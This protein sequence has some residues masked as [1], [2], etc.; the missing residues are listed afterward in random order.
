MIIDIVNS[1]RNSCKY[2]SVKKYSY[3]L[4][5]IFYLLLFF[6]PLITNLNNLKTETEIKIY[7][8]EKLF[9]LIHKLKVLD[10]PISYHTFLIT[11]TFL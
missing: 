9:Y 11:V 2:I 3:V 8:K 10:F 1:M 5:S 4:V 7:Y 6:L